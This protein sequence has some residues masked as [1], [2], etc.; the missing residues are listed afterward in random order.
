MYLVSPLFITYITTGT[1]IFIIMQISVSPSI[2]MGTPLKYICQLIL[3]THSLELHWRIPGLC[4]GRPRLGPNSFI[5]IFMQ[6][7]AKKLCQIIG[8]RTSPPLAD[9]G[10]A[11]EY[12]LF[13]FRIIFNL[14]GVNPNSWI[15]LTKHE[16]VRKVYNFPV[17]PSRLICREYW[18]TNL[19]KNLHNKNLEHPT[20]N[21]P[22][23]IFSDR[24][25]LYN[26][27]SALCSWYW[28][29]RVIAKMCQ[30]RLRIWLMLTQTLG[31]SS[32][33]RLRRIQRMP[34]CLHTVSQWRLP[35][36]TEEQMARLKKR[37]DI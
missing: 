10:S 7:S 36:Y 19:S 1:W 35:C 2:R 13:S 37:Y 4:Y 3:S 23:F 30:P 12:N 9:H 15:V 29:L 34:S 17:I 16:G 25:C 14:A 26:R 24:R 22:P 8:W 11:P 28:S 18:Q 20:Y 21:S 27:F 31:W 5:F 32:T 33:K 6:F